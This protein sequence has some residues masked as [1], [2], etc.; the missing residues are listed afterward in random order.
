M[1]RS[2]EY[3][4][5][6]IKDYLKNNFN[7]NHRVLDMGAGCGTYYDLLSDYFNIIDAVEVYKPNIVN[8]N[9]ESKYR[10]VYNMDICNFKLEY[11]DIVIFG[12]VIEHLSVEDAQKV[13]KNTYSKCKEMIVAVPYLYKQGEINGNIYEIHKQDDLTPKIMKQRY[14]YLKLLYGNDEYGY[15]IKGEMK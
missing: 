10:K 2:Y 8:Y 7:R 3:F 1:A 12:D 6:D 9:L 13:L 4:K 14:P 15:Y 5:Q 11:C